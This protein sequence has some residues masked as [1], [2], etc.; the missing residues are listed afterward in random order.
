[1]EEQECPVCGRVFEGQKCSTCGYESGK[2]V[3]GNGRDNTYGGRAAFKKESA[4]LRDKRLL[5]ALRM[6]QEAASSSTPPSWTL[7]AVTSSIAL[8]S[9][10][11]EL[12][13]RE[14]IEFN[15]NERSLLEHCHAVLAASDSMEQGPCQPPEIYIMLGNGFFIIGN[16]ERSLEYYTKAILRDPTNENALFN[17]AVVL[18]SMSRYQEAKKTLEKLLAR[19][20]GSERAAYLREL[21]EQ[22]DHTSSQT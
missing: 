3:F 20:P 16:R 8:L 21:A 5:E 11:M 10:P 14:N 4:P 18:F 1:M 7:D 15:E 17:Q 9:I 13:A 6:M 22:T 12:Q 2:G 19:N